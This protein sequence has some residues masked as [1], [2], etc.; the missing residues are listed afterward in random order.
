ME[1]ITIDKSKENNKFQNKTKKKKSRLSKQSKILI[2]IFL[3]CILLNITAWISTPFCDLY[4]RYIFPLWTSTY[5][6]LTSLLPFSFG[7]ILIMI[8]VFGIPLSLVAMI[9][10]IIVMKNRR[11]KVAKIFG[12]VYCW[13]IAFVMVTE[14]LNCFILY[15]C[16][17][18]AQ[19]NNIKVTEHTDEELEALGNIII[20]R[21]NEL[22]DKVKRDKDGNFVLSSD[23]NETAKK[24]LEKLSGK[25]KNL[26]GYYVKSKPV[27]CS[28]F[29]SQINLMGIY[30]PFS[31]EANYNNDMYKAKLPDTVCHE[32]AHTKG[33]I[34]EDEA[35]FIAFM[36]CDSSDSYDY[37][38]SG[39]LSAFT[40]VRNK[41]FEYADMDKKVKF[42]S[43]LSEDVWHD[44]SENQKYWESV[45]NAQDTIIDSKKAG[46]ISD[47]AMN[48]SLKINGVHDGTRSYG[49]V[50]DLMLD[51]FAEK[52]ELSESSQTEKNKD[53]DSSENLA[54][55]TKWQLFD[56]TYNETDNDTATKNYSYNSRI[57]IDGFV[58]YGQDNPPV[59]NMRLGNYSFADVGCEVIATYNYL[60]YEG[61]KTDMAKL[62]YDFEKNA[63]FKSDGSLGSNPRQIDGLFRTMGMKFQKIYTTAQAQEALD[64]GR[65]AII[66][67]HTGYNILSGIHTVFA[68]KE[69]GGI[70]V[71]NRENSK[72]DRSEIHDIQELV[73]KNSLFVIGY[74][75]SQ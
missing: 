64:E 25:F 56:D 72:K 60:R 48:S 28:F 16:S 4:N 71:Y 9:V 42:D 14:T 74:T 32:L 65:P 38:Y 33:Y 10:L 20:T 50:V 63:L 30:F 21:L 62:A 26:D 34:Q 39:Y 23:L 53:N 55:E 75:T 54:D 3:V 5:G 19:V 22:S 59:C 12:F 31:M 29:M 45:E 1:N 66:S 52:G 58:K 46:E 37:Q 18:F 27:I 8:G 43:S 57:K 13:I 7:E 24:S 17:T 68:V 44:I 36:A 51:Y 47:K 6:R 61:M 67:F 69:D 2:I 41:I 49:R 73:N 11:K 15:H 40:Q 70:Y 35:S